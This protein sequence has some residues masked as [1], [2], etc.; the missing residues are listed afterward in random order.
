[1]EKIISWILSNWVDI[2]TLLIATVAVFFACRANKISSEANKRSDEANRLSSKSIA[3]N[4]DATFNDFNIQLRA[5]EINV[6][7]LKED[8]KKIKSQNIEYMYSSTTGIMNE[9]MTLQ[10]QKKYMRPSEYHYHYEELE[11]LGED[12]E[13][14][15]ERLKKI[16]DS[17]KEKNLFKNENFSNL[18]NEILNDFDLIIKKIETKISK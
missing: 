7:K 11:S 5:N 18:Y 3:I 9:I 17:S 15:C 8:F 12:I 10:S 4:Y 2:S 6:M 13:S 16:A 14:K 1:M